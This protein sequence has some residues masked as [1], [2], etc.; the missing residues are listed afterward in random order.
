VL[1]ILPPSETKVSGGLEGTRLELSSLSFPALLSVRESM[2]AQVVALSGDTEASLKALKLGPQGL[3]EVARNQEL[4][5]SPLLPALSR[6]TGVLYDALHG[7]A[8]EPDADTWAKNNVAV[9]SAL[10]GLIRGGD[11]IPAYRLS[12]DS[13]VPG[14]KI[15]RQWEPHV[16]TLWE[17]VEGFV[18]DLRSEGYRSL[19]PVP[20]GRGVYGALVQSGAVGSRKALGHTNKAVKGQL[21]QRLAVSRPTINS[22]EDFVEWGR[23]HG[24]DVDPHSHQGGRIDLVISGS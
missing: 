17:Q 23:Q 20:E 13:S 1:V 11:L 2:V 15:S 5:S 9:F 19:G 21:V 24:Y 8:R 6:Y 3:G 7:E 22:V 18:L 14:G 10:F 16:A 12:W 4:L